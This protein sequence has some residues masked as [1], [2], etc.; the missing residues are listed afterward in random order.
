V[1]S[2]ESLIYTKSAIPLL[3]SCNRTYTKSHSVWPLCLTQRVPVRFVLRPYLVLT[4]TYMCEL[5]YTDFSCAAD[6]A[7]R[8]EDT[9]RLKHITRCPQ[10]VAR[11]DTCHRDQMTRNTDHS[12]NETWKMCPECRGETPPESP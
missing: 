4:I 1:V 10:A 2:P 8:G 5:T 9:D 11:G 12:E 7:A 3:K 6:H